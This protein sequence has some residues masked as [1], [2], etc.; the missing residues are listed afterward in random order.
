MN[1]YEANERPLETAPPRISR[2]Q[3]ACESV[4][5][6]IV[7]SGLT[8]SVYTVIWDRQERL[9]GSI[10]NYNWSPLDD[11]DAM[12]L[13]MPFGHILYSFFPPGWIFWV[14]F[15]AALR[16]RQRRAYLLCAGGGVAFGIYWPKHVVAMLGI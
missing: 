13:L 7:S 6:G 5:V 9:H 4:L 10:E 16:S 3:A 14:G 11:F 15:I 1:A 2:A 8:T 12:L